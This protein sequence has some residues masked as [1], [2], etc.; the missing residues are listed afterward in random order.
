MPAGRQLNIRLAPAVRDQLEALAFLRRIPSATLA[1]DIVVEYL[2]LHRHT[3]GLGAVLAG[4]SEHDRDESRS[5]DVTQLAQQRA[6]RSEQPAAG[7]TSP[8][9]EDTQRH[10]PQDGDHHQ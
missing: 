6:R 10:P 3:P 1:R 2:E 8:R 7:R 4:L 5:A 9:P